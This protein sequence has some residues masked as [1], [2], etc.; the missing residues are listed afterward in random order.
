VA[1]YSSI[2]HRLSRGVTRS[3]WCHT[4]IPPD[5][6]GSKVYAWCRERCQRLGIVVDAGEDLPEMVTVVVTIIT[7]AQ[8]TLD[9]KHPLAG[10]D[11]IFDIMLG[12]IL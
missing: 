3:T 9:A 6:L 4:G 7:E 1:S 5:D 12:E 8:M 10:Q 11:L 2:I